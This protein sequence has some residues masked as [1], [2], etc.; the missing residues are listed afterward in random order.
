M[1]NV[2][3]GNDVFENNPY[4]DH[5]HLS[6]TEAEVL[7]QYAKLSQN[8]KEVRRRV[9]ILQWFSTAPTFFQ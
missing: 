8:I 1:T 5:P 2:P 7:W 3:P 9:R 6:E 4:E